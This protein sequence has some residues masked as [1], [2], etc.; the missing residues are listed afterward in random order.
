VAEFL[1][2]P[3]SGTFPA[4][5]NYPLCRVKQIL[6][7]SKR[8]A[9][10]LSGENN[11]KNILSGAALVALATVATPA[12]ADLSGNVGYDSEYIFR[13]VPQSDS[14]ANG[15]VDWEA[16]I[17]G[18]DSKVGYYAGIWAAD[19][20][21]GLEVDYYAGV[22]ADLGEVSL[23]L[24][25]T[26]YDYTDDF[27]DAYTELNLG[28]DW[29]FLSAAIAVGEYDNFGGPTQDYEYYELTAE[30]NGFFAT[31]GSFANDF[32]GEFVQL[33]YGTTIATVDVTASYVYSNSDLVDGVG[34]IEGS[35]QS[36]IVQVSKGF[37][38]DQVKTAWNGLQQ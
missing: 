21:A 30:H 3:N 9:R 28:A 14:S 31:I 17:G 37:S 12:Q 33:G 16:G 32:D 10:T 4:L 36:F 6:I 19:V 27:D 23:L 24:G 35:D 8:K 1:H 18:S 20:D 34:G 7:L 22:T 25:G 29:K 26:Y 2:L 5:K 38:W 13:G 15:G 11:M